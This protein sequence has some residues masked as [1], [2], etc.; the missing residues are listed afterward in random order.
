M[1][2]SDDVSLLPQTR[3]DGKAVGL[4]DPGGLWRSICALG[5]WCSY[6]VRW[7]RG[8]PSPTISHTRYLGDA[9]VVHLHGI[10]VLHSGIVMFLDANFILGL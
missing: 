2:N 3:E 6:K 1:L 9:V 7:Q 8:A 5:P 4:V 10:K